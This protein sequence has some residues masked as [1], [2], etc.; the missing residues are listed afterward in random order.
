MTLRC[1]TVRQPWA[2]AIA[3]G[4]KT[5]ELRSWKV[6]HRGPLGIHAGLGWDN[7]FVAKNVKNRYACLIPEATMIRA[8]V[9]CGGL[10]AVADLVDI[11]E[12]EEPLTGRGFQRDVDRH[13]CV[14]AWGAKF[15]WV[16]E[17]VRRVKYIPWIGSQGLWR[18]TGEIEWAY[19]TT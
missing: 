1:L 13:R 8:G 9:E 2:S 5:I 12:Y 14:P 4:V 18:W 10:I 11:K 19:S 6:S 7:S 15:G 17:N 16:L 3:D